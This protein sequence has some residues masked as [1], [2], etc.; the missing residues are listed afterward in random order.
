MNVIGYHHINAKQTMKIHHAKG[1]G[2]EP[3][4]GEGEYQLP[5]ALGIL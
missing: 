3:T 1:Q 5:Q 2:K 4:D